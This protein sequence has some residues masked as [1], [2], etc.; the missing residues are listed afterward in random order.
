[1][2]LVDRLLGLL[3]T[4]ISVIEQKNLSIK[5]L[6]RLITGAPRRNAI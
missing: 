5:R 3:L 6:K 1:L 2:A 4:L